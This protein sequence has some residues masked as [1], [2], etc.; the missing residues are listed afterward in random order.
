M[1]GAAIPR[2]EDPRL[3]RGEGR[4]LD[5]LGHDAYQIAIVR[6]PHA[7]ARITSIDVSAAREAEGVVA[8]V[9]YD[10][11]PPRLQEPLPL[12]IP[13]PALTAGRTQYILANG[14]VNHAG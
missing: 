4:Y 10:D 2:S 8:V 9:T 11:L 12:L 3:L 14:E 7:H 6:S 13:H 1:M 5:D